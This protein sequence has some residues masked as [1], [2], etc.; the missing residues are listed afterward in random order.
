MTF[1]FCVCI[2]GPDPQLVRIRVTCAVSRRRWSVCEPSQICSAV[3]SKG[4]TFGAVLEPR[5]V[6]RLEDWINQRGL[7]PS[8]PSF[9]CETRLG[10]PARFVGRTSG[11][12]T[13]D[14][15]RRG[16][17]DEEQSVEVPSVTDKIFRPAEIL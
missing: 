3:L 6:R 1:S 5:E 16:V 10:L 14:T 17:V 7:N 9:R 13:G 2:Y 12:P 15:G 4:F 11:S 8:T